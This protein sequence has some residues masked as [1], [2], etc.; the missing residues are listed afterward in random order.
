M[1]PRKLMRTKTWSF[2]KTTFP[3]RFCPNG[4][5][6]KARSRIEGRI[7]PRTNTIWNIE[8][9]ND[10]VHSLLDFSTLVYYFI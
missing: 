2:E 10:V 6:A 7:E 1:A 4:C 9:K 5:G 3:L 8:T